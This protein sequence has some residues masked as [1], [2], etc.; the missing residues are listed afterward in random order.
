MPNINDLYPSRYLKQSDLKGTTPVVTMDR[1][2]IET[3]GEG[4]EA[5]NKPVLYFAGK[6]KGL[7]LNKTNTNTIASLYGDETDDWK[8]QPVQLL[9]APVS[10]NGKT[11]MAI[12]ISP[13]KPQMA[14][15]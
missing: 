3:L 4:E 14:A 9:S 13:E 12:R 6:E 2:A 8:G 10:Y 1:L 7:V 15:A 5:E 11:T